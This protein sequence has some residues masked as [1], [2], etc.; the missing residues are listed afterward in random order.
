[1][2]IIFKILSYISVF[3]LGLYVASEFKFNTPIEGYRWGM[4]IFTL[5]IWIVL[6]NE[7]KKK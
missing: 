6:M 2:N 1:M 7:Y 5:I 3:I 4:T